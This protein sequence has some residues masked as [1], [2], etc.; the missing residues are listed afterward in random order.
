MSKKRGLGKG[1][2]ALFPENAMI[3]DSKDDLREIAV[4]AIKPNVQQPRESFDNSKIDELA[5][6]IKQH[7]VIQP[8]VVRPLREGGY[9]IIAGERRW[10][11]CEKLGLEFIPA[12]VKRC[13]AVESAIISM[14]ENIQREDLNPLEEAQAYRKIMDDYN[15][16]Q[17]EISKQIGKSRPFIANMTRLLSLPD[18]VKGL[19]KEGYIKPGH[20]RAL[21]S[22][23]EAA[24][25]VAVAKEIVAS[26]YNVRETEQIVKELTERKHKKR[27]RAKTK[28]EPYIDRME[29]KLSTVFSTKVI[30]RKGKNSGGR[31][32]IQYKDDN[33]LEKIFKN[34]AIRN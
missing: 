11:A 9:E 22:L 34:I 7:G 27:T 8:V 30:I 6:S 23:K 3:S 33:E 13:S 5:H 20:A 17:E 10:R 14:I 29:R 24:E 28:K 4:K 15:L 21:L 1:L 26:G 12:V 31:I 2:S 18:E 25:Q 32:V 16:T 19:I